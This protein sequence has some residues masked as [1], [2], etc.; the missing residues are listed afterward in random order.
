MQP[1]G[2]HYEPGLN[3]GNPAPP[4]PVFQPSN[5][6]NPAPLPPIFQASNV[7]PE[8]VQPAQQSV[9]PLEPQ[10]NEQSDTMMYNAR[11]SPNDQHSEAMMS[12]GSPPRDLLSQNQQYAAEYAPQEPQNG[13]YGQL[14]PRPNSS[15][16]I[17]GNFSTEGM[18]RDM[19]PP[20]A[21]QPPMMGNQPPRLPPPEDRPPTQWFS[22][23]PLNPGALGGAAPVLAPPPRIPVADNRPL[24]QWFQDDPRPAYGQIDI[25]L[26]MDQRG[27]P[28]DQ[29]EPTFDSRFSRSDFGT[30]PR[31]LEEID[32]ERY[33]VPPF[34]QENP[35]FD[36]Y[37][38]M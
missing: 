7:S 33:P 38:R 36:P 14:S 13:F 18:P 15:M 27:R 12:N 10:R 8:V 11:G 24:T 35:P 1:G 4:A 20:L 26:A 37:R 31:R 19:P 17:N 34:P 5:L 25:S 30:L 16:M 3:G 28:E 32:Q 9:P 6:G 21:Q 22:D 23:D 29:F 2:R